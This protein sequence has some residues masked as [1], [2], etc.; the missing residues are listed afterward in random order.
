MT[1]KVKKIERQYVLS[2]SSVNVYGF[3]LLTSG[4]QLDDYRKNPIGYYMHR[5]EDGIALKWED[6][7]IE[8]DKVI[9]TP[10]INLS[11]ARGTQMCDEAENG[12]LNAASVGH[13]VVLEYSTDPEMMLPGQTGPTITKWYNKECSLVDI[14]G[15]NNELTTLYDA[16][17]NEINLVDIGAGLQAIKT[18]DNLWLADLKSALAMDSNAGVDTLVNKIKDLVLKAET[19][20][21]ENTTLLND[22]QVL[23]QQ[24]DELKKNNATAEIIAVL[25][26][27]LE[28]RKITVSLKDRLAVDYADNAEGLKALIAAMS[29]YRTIAESLRAGNDTTET[30]WAWD[31]YEK[32]DPAG[33]KLKALRANDPAR[34]KDLFDKK[35]AA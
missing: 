32:N 25:D 9:G 33:K 29:A 15:N 10:V 22:K 17:E 31:D 21:I 20:T 26:R 13:I 3:R 28:D 27:A 19:L 8:D 35:F 7:R 12:F 16:Q 18:A 1:E 34:Y 2:D 23:V 4:Y 5:R 14:P 11:N 6:L 30:Q 24:I